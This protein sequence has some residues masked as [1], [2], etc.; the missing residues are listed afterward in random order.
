MKRLV[1]NGVLQQ[2]DIFVV[3][4][5]SIHFQGDNIG[6]ADA[7]WDLYQIRFIALPPYSPEFN[8]TELVFNCLQHRLKCER[9]RYKAIDAADFLDAIMLELDSF[10]LLDVVRF[11][12]KCGYLK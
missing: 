2:G 9:A 8:P 10:D 4:N 7:L 3:D 12:K 6:L 11:Y 1:E 5:C